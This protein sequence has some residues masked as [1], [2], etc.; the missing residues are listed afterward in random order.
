[1]NVTFHTM[2]AL[3]TAAVLSSQQDRQPF[4]EK[5]TL[6]LAAGGFAAGILLHGLLDYLPHSYPIPSTF[7]VLLSLALVCAALFLAN[8]ECRF[9]IAACFLGSIFPDILDLGPPFANKLLGWSLPVAKLFPWHWPRYS[10][11]IYDGSRRIESLL[12]H[13]AVILISIGLIYAN[14]WTM[15][16]KYSL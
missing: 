14:R 4:R 13:S 3:A 16:S 7:D 11:S 1:M 9:L 12:L 15:F 10:G 6:P 5:G 2:T 8:R